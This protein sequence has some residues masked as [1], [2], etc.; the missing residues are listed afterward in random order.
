MRGRGRFEYWRELVL[1]LLML[2][3]LVLGLTLFDSLRPQGEEGGEDTA[4][5]TAE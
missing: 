1:V 4:V 2:T 5:M 3:V